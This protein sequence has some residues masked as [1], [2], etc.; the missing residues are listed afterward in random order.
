MVLQVW[1]VNDGPMNELEPVTLILDSGEELH[2]LAHSSHNGGFR[3]TLDPT[4]LP[5]PT[6]I[7]QLPYHERPDGLVAVCASLDGSSNHHLARNQLVSLRFLAKDGSAAE[8]DAGFLANFR[9]HP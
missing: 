8:K 1:L 6:V 3:L 4:H 5:M 9:L 7:A 2:C